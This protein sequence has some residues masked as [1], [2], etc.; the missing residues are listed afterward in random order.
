MHEL[1]H[2]VGF[3]HEQSRP[4]RDNYVKILY[5]NIPEKDKHNFK[6]LE[7]DAINS[8]QQVFSIV[9]FFLFC[10]VSIQKVTIPDIKN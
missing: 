8:L 3:W 6:K 1:G 7:E 4:D 10:N 5:G 9:S 2:S